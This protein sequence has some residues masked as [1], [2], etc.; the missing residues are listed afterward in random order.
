MG[1]QPAAPGSTGGTCENRE[2]AVRVRA[3]VMQLPL[4]QREIFMLFRYQGLSYQEIARIQGVSVRTVDSR[5]YRAMKS[6]GQLL[7][8]LAPSG[9]EEKP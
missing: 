6:L 3:K 4:S 9:P 8:G 7:S 1:A 2:L 5:L